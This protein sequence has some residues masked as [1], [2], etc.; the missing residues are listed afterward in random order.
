MWRAAAG[1]KL[2]A[3]LVL[4]KPTNPGAQT[5]LFNSEANVFLAR[6]S[7]NWGINC[8]DLPVVVCN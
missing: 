4:S 7:I 6:N 2:P 3:A 5:A 1:K 8:R